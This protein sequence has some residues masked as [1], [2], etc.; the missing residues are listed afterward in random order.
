VAKY[1]QEVIGVADVVDCSARQ[2]AGLLMAQAQLL[3]HFVPEIVCGLSSRQGPFARQT[4]A[5]VGDAGVQPHVLWITPGILVARA[6]W[7][8]V[9]AFLDFQ[10]AVQFMEHDVGKDGTGDSALWCA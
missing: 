10:P 3:P 8:W 4:A 9:H 7:W 1:N 5:Q 6:L 2:T